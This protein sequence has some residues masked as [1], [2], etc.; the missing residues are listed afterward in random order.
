MNSEYT[1]DRLL[2]IMEQLRSENGCPW[3]REQTNESIKNDTVE[4]VYELVEAI[5]NN[6]DDNL[7]E[8]LG[9]LLLHVV[10]HSQIGK[11]EGRFS[12]EDVLK[13]IIDK[14]I[15]RHPH[16]FSDEIAKD[17]EEVLVQWDE[18]KKIEKSH[19]NYT[20]TLR[21]VPKAMPALIRASKVGKKAA[22]SGFDFENS[23]QMFA[24]LTEEMQ[25][26]K[27]AIEIGNKDYIQEE[28]GDMLFQIVNIS[29]FFQLNP[30]NAL[31]NSTEKFINRFEGIE[32]LAL[33]DSKGLSDLSLSEMDEYWER[34]KLTESD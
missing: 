15:R 28:I 3:D 33:A 19:K 10:F 1:F 14:M 11:D 32:Q 26:T 21:S 12:I 6:D 13:S 31:T 2:K 9:D 22:K 17:S 29:R 23:E 27:E 16:V 4:E 20:D 8:E 18:I 7:I 24:K 25:E 30:E 34:I 5:N